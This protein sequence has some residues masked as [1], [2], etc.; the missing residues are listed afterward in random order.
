MKNPRIKM[1]E[2]EFLNKEK[3]NVYNKKYGIKLVS[4]NNK[5]ILLFSQPCNQ[6]YMEFIKIGIQTNIAEKYILGKR[7]GKGNFAKVNVGF[8]KKNYQQYAIKS[9][10]KAK[11]LENSKAL[12]I[13][14]RILLKRKLK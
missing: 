3:L 11:I 2:K 13:L 1:F 4:N 6:I 7:I 14:L 12:V 5:I 9:I 8:D 10:S